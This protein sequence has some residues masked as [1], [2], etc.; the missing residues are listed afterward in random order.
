MPVTSET[1]WNAARRAASTLSPAEDWRRDLACAVSDAARAEFVSIMTCPPDDWSRFHFTTYPDDRASLVTQIDRDF[2]PRIEAVGEGWQQ[3]VR[4]HGRVYT[5]LEVVSARPLAE[6]LRDV[7]IRP[8]DIDGYV[9]A[10]LLDRAE[11]LVGM[12]ALGARCDGRE[13][14]SRII[15]PLHETIQLAGSTL[16]GALDLARAC[17]A[18]P[19]ALDPSLPR[20][21]SPLRT[22]LSSRELEVASL[23]TEGLSNLTI[24]ARLG[25]AETTVA[26]HL[27]RIFGKLGVRSRVQLAMRCRDADAGEPR[28]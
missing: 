7:V 6:E 8:A 5:P 14:L 18:P 20:S 15:D 16:G 24:G 13:L 12:V 23:V 22:A 4:A 21:T 9:V 2:K 27:R 17:G 25:I 19:P 26:V 28:S 10:F 3:A 1:K 11:H